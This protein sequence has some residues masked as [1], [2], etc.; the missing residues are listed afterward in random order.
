MEV[1][2]KSK[3]IG[4]MLYSFKKHFSFLVLVLFSSRAMFGRNL[5]SSKSRAAIPFETHSIHPCK[6]TLKGKATCRLDRK[7]SPRYV[8]VA[9]VYGEICRLL[10]IRI[11]PISYNFFTRMWHNILICYV[12][13]IKKTT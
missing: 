8:Y 9:R 1:T 4:Y 6:E 10:I 7:G 11:S 13:Y 2:Y 3:Y 5:I 12:I